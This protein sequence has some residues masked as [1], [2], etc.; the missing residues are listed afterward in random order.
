MRNFA[1]KI[2][3]FQIAVRYR[4]LE[5]LFDDILKFDRQVAKICRKVSRQ[6]AVLIKRMRNVLPFEVRKNIYFSFVA[7]H[8]DY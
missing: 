3:S 4:C 5:L 6:V 8:F 2:T 7:P 1:A